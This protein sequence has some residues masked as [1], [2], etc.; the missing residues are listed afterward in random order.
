MKLQS[1]GIEWA[2]VFVEMGKK[3]EGSV[4]EISAAAQIR[5]WTNWLERVE[6]GSGGV[7]EWTNSDLFNS[8]N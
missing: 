8:L 2:K 5:L 1:P 4:G 3:Q 6:S 7:E